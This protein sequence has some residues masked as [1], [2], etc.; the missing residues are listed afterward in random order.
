MVEI[1]DFYPFWKEKQEKLRKDSGLHHDIWYLMY[2]HGYDPSNPDE[3]KRFLADI[4]E[5]DE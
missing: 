5:E 2:D 1:I 4:E 3:L